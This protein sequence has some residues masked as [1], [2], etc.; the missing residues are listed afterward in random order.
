MAYLI[1]ILRQEIHNPIMD[2]LKKWLDKHFETVVAQSGSG[3]T[4]SLG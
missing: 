2:K 4:L 3:I 1:H